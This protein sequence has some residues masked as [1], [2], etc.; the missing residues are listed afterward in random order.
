MA[1]LDL[2]YN[3]IEFCPVSL[4]NHVREVRSYQGLVCGYYHHFEIIYLGKFCRLCVSSTGHACKF[5][6]HSEEILESD[7]SKRLVFA[8]Y[9]HT[10]FCLNGLVQPV[11]PPPARHNPSGK[12]VD[13]DNL[14]VF[15]HIF[16]VS[17]VKVVRPEALKYVM[18]QFNI[19]RLIEVVYTEQLL[20]FRIA[21]LAKNNRLQLFVDFKIILCLKSRDNA[22][23]L[24]ILIGRLLR[25]SRYNKRRPR[26]IDQDAV[27]LVNDCEV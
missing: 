22:V 18:D 15:D 27:H 20:H 21:R 6:I 25:G 12:L 9:L 2:Q 26:L 19:G 24:I 13:Y 3:S 17:L 11:T 10:L 7:S 4:V 8:G 23:N 16:N 1:L 5:V 14:T